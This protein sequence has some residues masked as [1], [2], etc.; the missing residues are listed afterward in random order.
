MSS[1]KQEC[2]YKCIGVRQNNYRLYHDGKHNEFFVLTPKFRI[3][4]SPRRINPELAD[5]CNKKIE[6]WNEAH[7]PATTAWNFE[8][9][10][11]I[12]FAT[13]IRDDKGIYATAETFSNEYIGI[14][15]IRDILT[16]GK[17][18]VG[19]YYSI[20]KRHNEGE[21]DIIDEATLLEIG[22][23]LAPVREEY[24]FKI[25]EEKK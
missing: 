2:S 18:G 13:P 5:W 9:D 24:Y 16:D 21:L 20:N 14:K 3:T 1:N 17:I 22:L 4:Q 23:T 11:P 15:D 19:G 25:V 8:H 7:K 10:K 12:G 6:E